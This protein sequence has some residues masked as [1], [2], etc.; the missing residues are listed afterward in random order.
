M[1]LTCILVPCAHLHYSTIPLL[2]DSFI[3]LPTSTAQWF[4]S[5]SVPPLL[6]YG[7]QCFRDSLL[8]GTQTYL[9]VNSAAYCTKIRLGPKFIKSN[10]LL[11]PLH[12]HIGSNAETKFSDRV[13]NSQ[14]FS[15]FFVGSLFSVKQLCEFCGN[16]VIKK[17]AGKSFYIQNFLEPIFW[18]LTN[19][20]N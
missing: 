19:D 3:S 1:V 11:Y 2:N 17:V 8:N 15:Y 14:S 5:L 16:G 4:I 7:D 18:L 9:C 20:K 12:T 6:S 13:L 10:R